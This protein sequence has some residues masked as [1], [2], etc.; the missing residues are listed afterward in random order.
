PAPPALEAVTDTTVFP[1]F[2]GASRLEEAGYDFILA[3]YVDPG[4][5]ETYQNLAY[6]M[7]G[8]GRTDDAIRAASKGLEVKPDDQR[9]KQNLRAAVMGKAVSLYNEGK[10]AESIV[11]F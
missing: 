7:G 2:T 11:E 5:V 9:L 1:P 4:S 8:L 10:Y 6:V 3:S